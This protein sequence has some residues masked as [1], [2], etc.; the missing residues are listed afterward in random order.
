MAIGNA[1]I[2]LSARTSLICRTTASLRMRE[3][4]SLDSLKEVSDREALVRM[5]VGQRQQAL[6]GQQPISVARLGGPGA[7]A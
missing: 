2:N 6:G 4:A 7:R 3:H 1:E 5:Q